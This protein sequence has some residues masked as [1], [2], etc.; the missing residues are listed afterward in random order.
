[1][2]KYYFHNGEKQLGAFD[3]EELKKYK[4]NKDTPVWYDELDE[5]TTAGKVEELRD[6]LEKEPPTFNPSKIDSIEDNDL[7]SESF[8]KKYRFIIITIVFLLISGL[9]FYS[10]KDNTSN[11]P[12]DENNETFINE[13]NETLTFPQNEETDTSNQIAVDE[14]SQSNSSNRKKTAEQI[15]QD[16]LQSEQNSPLNYISIDATDKPNRVKTRNGTFFRSSKHKIDGALVVGFISNRA[17]LA[18]FKDIVYRV[19]Y[20]SETGTVISSEE[21]TIYDYL[22]PQSS[23]EINQKV[24]PPKGTTYISCEIVRASYN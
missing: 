11:S 22:Y 4:I 20:T 21:F 16:L 9:L 19:N 1:M 14:E 13:S 8:L 5:W 7:N 18:E 6:I 23:L 10:L 12:I 2:T 3:K 15:K 24:Y 17:T